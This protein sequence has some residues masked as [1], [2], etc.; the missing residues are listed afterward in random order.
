MTEETDTTIRVTRLG[1]T[2]EFSGR[3][4]LAAHVEGF[5]SNRVYAPLELACIERLVQ[6]GNGDV[7]P[8]VKRI[9]RATSFVTSEGGQAERARAESPFAS[10]IEELRADL[11]E[12]EA[13][14]GNEL[15]ILHSLRTEL[16]QV[17]GQDDRRAGQLR[18]RIREKVEDVRSARRAATRTRAA[19]GK[20]KRA[21][22]RWRQDRSARFVVGS[23]DARRV[24]DREGLHAY[25]DAERGR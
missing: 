8:D 6:L 17:R 19:L 1:E 24:V 12:A 13:E 20:A 5:V 15:E 14:H 11:E 4:E 3:E 23:P 22:D 7:P 2:L 9:E 10:R 21:A 25:L 18:D 16:R